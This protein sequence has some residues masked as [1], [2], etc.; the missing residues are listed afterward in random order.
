MV[1][2]ADATLLLDDRLA[3]SENEF[4]ELVIW[5]VPSP[6]PS[7]SHGYKY[8][9]AFVNNEVCVVRFDNEAGK[10]DH[11][12]IGGRETAYAFSNVRTLQDDFWN[13]MN[14]WRKQH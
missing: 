2:N 4:V 6:V 8:R 5:H 1:T 7:S 9:L 3:L 12:H 11:R 14:Q 13:D 10:G